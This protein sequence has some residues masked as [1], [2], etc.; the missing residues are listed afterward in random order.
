MGE[1][2]K[3]GLS[4][5]TLL[6]KKGGKMN[7]PSKLCAMCGARIDA[8]VNTVITLEQKLEAQA[9]RLYRLEQRLN[10]LELASKGRLTVNGQR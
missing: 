4:S 3:V 8:L 9:E 7:D 2:K 6:L 1:T 10:L 5:K